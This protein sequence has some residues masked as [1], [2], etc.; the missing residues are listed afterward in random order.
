MNRIIKFRAYHTKVKEMLFGS[1]R[2]TG[3]WIEEK[4]P[5]EV[6][7]FTGLTDKNGKEIYE[8]DI[9][10]LD[11]ELEQFELDLEQPEKP[12][13]IEHFVSLFKME[14]NERYGGILPVLL[15]AEVGNMLDWQLDNQ[16]NDYYEI[17]GNIYENG[18]LLEK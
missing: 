12:N 16:E 14:F 2:E 3:Q 8:G 4:Q 13:P 17:I 18:N 11:I 1:L 6:M 5:I 15:K 10:K 9:I 7:Q